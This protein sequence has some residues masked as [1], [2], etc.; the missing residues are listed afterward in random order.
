A[1]WRSNPSAI[2]LRQEFPVQRNSTRFF[3]FTYIALVA[4]IAPIASVASFT[5][6]L[7]PYTSRVTLYASRITHHA[8][9]ANQCFVR[10]Q[11]AHTESMTGTST[12]TPTT[13]ANAAPEPGPKRAIAVATASSKKLLAPI[14]APGAAMEWGTFSHFIRQ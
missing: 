13:V 2:W 10:L 12:R 8:P 9:C 6:L 5:S 11:T 14:K 1:R 4:S 3:G 7:T